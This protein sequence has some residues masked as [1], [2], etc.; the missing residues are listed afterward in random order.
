MADSLKKY[1]ENIYNILSNLDE[2]GLGVRDYKPELDVNNTVDLVQ[3][4]LIMLCLYLSASDGE[5]SYKEKLFMNE[6]FDLKF[7]VDEI[8]SFIR[9][10]E[11]R[12]FE[13]E[14]VIPESVKLM[15][16]ADNRIVE[17]GTPNSSGNGIMYDFYKLVG[18]AFIACDNDVDSSEIRDLGQFL[19]KIKDYINN[20]SKSTNRITTDPFSDAES[21]C[22]L[23]QQYKPEKINAEYSSSYIVKSPSDSNPAPW[24]TTYLSYACPYCGKKKVRYAKWEDKMLSTAFWGFYSYKLHCSYKCDNCK[25]MWN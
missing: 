23:L 9:D 22:N 13:F 17:A 4:D 8:K 5:I 20:N 2:V 6:C 1:V 12:S 18:Q 15:V 25:Q 21:A 24:D 7:S 11:I 14:E 19:L 3:S 10:R 16:Y